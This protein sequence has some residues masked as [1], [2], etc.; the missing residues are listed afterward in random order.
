MGRPRPGPAHR[1][2]RLRAGPACP[3]CGERRVWQ[4]WWNT[5][6]ACPSCALDLERHGW[7]AA[8]WINTWFAI[9][10]VVAWVVVGMIVTGGEGPLW[11]TSGAVAVAVA[12][13]VIGYRCAKALM[14]R[15]L[16]RFDPP[17]TT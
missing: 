9:V 2:V 17:A 13:P 15:L 4:S 6:P 11:V 3:A 16:H 7:L 8:V 5:S 10:S 12:V 1:D 14:L